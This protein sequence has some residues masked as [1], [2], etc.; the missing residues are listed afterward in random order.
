MNGPDEARQIAEII[1]Q[2]ER[3]FPAVP[4]REVEMIVAEE[5]T[6]LEGNPIRDYV[7]RLVEHGARSKLR[8]LVTTT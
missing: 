6:A 7:P 8:S 5:V 4:V 3:R 2:L 1:A